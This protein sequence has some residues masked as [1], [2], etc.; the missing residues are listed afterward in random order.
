MGV[1]DMGD[2]VDGVD[3]VGVQAK[4]HCGD[5]RDAEVH[6]EVWLGLVPLYDSRDWDPADG[7]QCAALA[8]ECGMPC[9]WWGQPYLLVVPALITHG[10]WPWGCGLLRVVLSLCLVVRRGRWFGGR[11]MDG[12]ALCDGW[13]LLST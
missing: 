7:L 10:C 4:E 11:E 9:C 6:H 3:V 5:G 13:L 8:M 12:S 1:L 2:A